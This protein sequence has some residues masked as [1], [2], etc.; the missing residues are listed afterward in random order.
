[1][2]KFT[3]ACFVVL[4]LAVIAGELMVVSSVALQQATCLDL[5]RWVKPFC[6][7]DGLPTPECKEACRQ[8][9]PST[10]RYAN[11]SNQNPRGCLCQYRC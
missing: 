11:C 4:A 1:M 8:R 10:F 5:L 3:S 6:Q 7:A 9:H 2:G